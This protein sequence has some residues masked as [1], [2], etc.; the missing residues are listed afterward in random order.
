MNPRL[1]TST[2]SG[3]IYDDTKALFGD[4]VKPGLGLNPILNYISELLK[5]LYSRVDLDCIDLKILG[6]D[7][8]DPNKTRACII[9]EYLINNTTD[10]LAAIARLN[11]LANTIQGSIG[12]FTDEKTSVTFG[13][14]P[15][16]L[17][18]VLISAPGVLT[19]AADKKTIYLSGTVPIGFTA[20]ISV[21]RLGDFDSSGKGKD[22]TDLWG[23]AIRNGQN[24]TLNV[25]GKFVRYADNPVDAGA[26]AGEDNF[27][28]GPEN[29]GTATIPVTGLLTES[30]EPG[31]SLDIP[32]GTF[33]HAAGGTSREIIDFNAGSDRTLKTTAY[34]FK[35]THGFTLNATH[36]NPAP[37][38][39]PLIPKHI[40]EIP[41]QRIIP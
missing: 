14:I 30:L 22:G 1:N 28:V 3:I 17:Q 15:G 13:G 38:A 16:Y 34:N 11:L 10:A 8:A 9:A 19:P 12:L 36:I 20:T 2:T 41:I 25:L 27:T 4:Q 32:V 35:H 24:G 6:I 26:I 31:L 23:W 40:T 18:D 29:L 5:D 39:I 33:S 7:C 37:T 21:S